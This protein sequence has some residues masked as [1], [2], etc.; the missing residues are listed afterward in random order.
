MKWWRIFEALFFTRREGRP[1]SCPR[2][3]EKGIMLYRNYTSNVCENSGSSIRT[4]HFNNK[5][6]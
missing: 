1:P 4:S 6:A 5:H 2:H 3:E